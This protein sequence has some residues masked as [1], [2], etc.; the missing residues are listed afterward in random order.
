MVVTLGMPVPQGNF[1]PSLLLGAAFGGYTGLVCQRSFLE[2]IDPADFALIGAAAFLAGMQRNTVSL[3]VILMEGTGQTKIVIPMIITVI[4]ARAVGDLLSE[5]IYEIGMELKKYPYLMHENKDR[6]DM[7]SVANIMNTNFGSVAMVERACDIESLLFKAK[8]NAF[9]VVDT[10]TGEYKGLV[11]RDQLIAAMECKIY[12]ETIAGTGLDS[13]EVATLKN[14]IDDE[15]PATGH[16]F[17]SARGLPRI[18]D[19]VYKKQSNMKAEKPDWNPNTPVHSSTWL[20][21]NVLTSVD[22]N[23]VVFGMDETLPNGRIKTNERAVVKT[24]GAKNVV[25]IPPKEKDMHIDVGS[26]M[27]KAA[28][29]VMSEFPLSKTYDLFVSM[30]LNNLPVLGKENKV[31]GMIAR[32]DLSDEHIEKMT[33]YALY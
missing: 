29:S 13:S 32:H 1:M 22:G 31:V 12:V 24:V 7:F 2:S 25:F 17:S 3:C 14:S 30:G 10:D 15:T 27:N 20:R 18:D 11:R 19:D 21:D 6:Y 28:L 23:E 4:S 8:H 33:G 5:G 26:I 16:T 9:V